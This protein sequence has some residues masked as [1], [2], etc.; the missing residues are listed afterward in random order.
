MS[1]GIEFKKIDVLS[2]GKISAIIFGVLA[3]FQVI[4]IS[5]IMFI[6]PEIATALGT[7][8][9]GIDSLVLLPLSGAISGFLIA[10]LIAIIYNLIAPKI[11]GIRV[12]A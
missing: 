7:S 4:L 12:E 9:Y 6:S 8:P 3:F 11:G 1:K 2:F 5:I 10:I